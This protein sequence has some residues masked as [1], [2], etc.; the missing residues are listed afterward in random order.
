MKWEI[1]EI[2]WHVCINRIYKI[3]Y[4][5]FVQKGNRRDWMAGMPVQRSNRTDYVRSVQ[6][7]YRR[8][9]MAYLYKWE[10]V[11]YFCTNEKYEKLYGISV[12]MRN[13]DDCMACLYKHAE[14]LTN[15]GMFEQGG[16]I[17]DYDMSVEMGNRTDCVACLY[18]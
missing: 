8:D 10:S 1:T 16:S 3:L 9:C 2:V 14:R 12:Q 6:V 11:W 7:G 4:G 17:K 18:K 5:M 15:G 13:R